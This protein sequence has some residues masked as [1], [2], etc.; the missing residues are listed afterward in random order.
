MV[1]RDAGKGRDEA[2]LEAHRSYVDIQFS[3]G[4]TDVIGWKSTGACTQPAGQYDPETD[5][6][7]FDDAPE[8]WIAV[9]PD[10]FAVFFPDDA[11]A[12]MAAEGELHKVVMKVAV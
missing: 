4:C 3:L 12:P 6:E 9:P 10:R 1:V 11:H 5:L 8:A 7:L 2:R